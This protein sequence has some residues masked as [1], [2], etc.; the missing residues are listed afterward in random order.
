MIWCRGSRDSNKDN[1]D[2]WNAL[3]LWNP[4]THGC[5]NMASSL[6]Q[7]CAGVSCCSWSLGCSKIWLSYKSNL[8][9][10]WMHLNNCRCFQ[11]HLRMLLHS[12][13][14]L[15]LAPGALGASWI[16]QEHWWGL[17]ECLR[18]VSLPS[19]PIYV[20]PMHLNHVLRHICCP[21]PW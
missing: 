13:R 5:E 20:L 10:S 15:C 9:A 21:T 7:S 3:W 8:E 6:L 2:T 4:K 17:P 11:E 14:A 19:T 12:L 16:T 18:G 1:P